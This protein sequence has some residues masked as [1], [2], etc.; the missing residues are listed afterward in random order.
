[1]KHYY[2]NSIEALSKRPPK[3]AKTAGALLPL[4]LPVELVRV[5]EVVPN[6]V[7]AAGDGRNGAQ[8]GGAKPDGEDGVLL[9]DALSAADAVVVAGANRFANGKLNNTANK[10]NAGDAQLVAKAHVAVHDAAHRNGNGNNQRHG[11]QVEGHPG[12]LH[13]P[14]VPPGEVHP[15]GP[16][17]QEGEDEQREHLVQDEQEGWPEVQRRAGAHQRE[18]QRYADGRGDVDEDGVADQRLGVAAQLAGNHGGGGGRWRNHAD[19]G[20]LDDHAV[21]RMGKEVEEQAE[22]AKRA[23]LDQQQPEVQGAQAQLV[24]VNLAERKEE[25]GKD[26]QRLKEANELVDERLRRHQQGDVHK[27]KVAQYSGE[28]G[29][30]K[31]PVLKKLYH[32]LSLYDFGRKGNGGG[33]RVFADAA[34]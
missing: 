18:H 15:H 32:Y 28:H 14:T 3:V 9:A 29:D 22:K 5:E 23:N 16:G 17:R 8:E 31:R 34:K 2:K 30:G 4:A 20:R 24:R 11:P 27:S 26:E 1:M 33:R 10:R 12:A 6:A 13:Q 21:G 25:H 7:E 19:H